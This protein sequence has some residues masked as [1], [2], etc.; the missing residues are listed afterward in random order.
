MTDNNKP[1]DITEMSIEISLTLFWVIV[2]QNDFVQLQE[3]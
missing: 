1:N 3:I 2:M